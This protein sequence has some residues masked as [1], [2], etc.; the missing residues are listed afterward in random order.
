MP[1]KTRHL[2]LVPGLLCDATVWQQQVAALA[3]NCQIQ[4]PRHDLTDNLGAMADRILAI[5]PPHF[6]LAGHS[7]GGRIALEVVARAPER[8]ERLALLDTGYE[9]LAAGDAGERERAGR[10]RL[11]DIARRDGMLAMARDWA[12]GMVHPSR[13]TDAALMDAI[14]QMLARAPVEMFEAQIK[15]LLG[16]ADRTAL[17]ARIAVP[18]LV[19]CG[20]DDAWSPLARHAD[21]AQRIAGSTLVDIPDCGHMCTMERPAPVSDAL[22]NWLFDRP[23]PLALPAGEIR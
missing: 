8:V 2:I 13:L 10:L 19:L 15:A 6:A 22:A 1:S 5:A 17:L 11:L 14:H 20:H 7:M 21:I 3:D 12:R 9:P 4:V 16:R 18:T 23:Q